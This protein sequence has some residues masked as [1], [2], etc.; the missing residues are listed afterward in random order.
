MRPTDLSNCAPSNVPVLPWTFRLGN[1]ARTVLFSPDPST[2]AVATRSI[3]SLAKTQRY[4]GWS[5]DESACTQN[6][7]SQQGCQV[8]VGDTIGAD[9]GQD[10][11]MGTRLTWVPG[12]T[13]ALLLEIKCAQKQTF[14]LC[15]LPSALSFFLIIPLHCQLFVIPH[16]LSPIWLSRTNPSPK[17]RSNPSILPCDYLKLSPDPLTS[18]PFTLYSNSHRKLSWLPCLVISSSKLARVICKV[19]SRLGF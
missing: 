2:L 4:P 14:H 5:R 19:F 3:P 10:G 17:L 9:H 13:P 1:A 15:I 7:G 12:D 16:V 11:C 8:A 18:S 6:E